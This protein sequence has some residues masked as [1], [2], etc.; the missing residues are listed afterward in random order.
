MTTIT[1]A[2]DSDVGHSDI[3]IQIWLDD[4]LNSYIFGYFVNGQA[5]R[6]LFR[7]CPNHEKGYY[8]GL[9]GLTI[10]QL[11]GMNKT[12]LLHLFSIFPPKLLRRFPRHECT[13]DVQSQPCTFFL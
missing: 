9:F 10:W 2:R 5:S 13:W 12:H 4:N 1:G 8:T 3:E 6:Q 7:T 11:L